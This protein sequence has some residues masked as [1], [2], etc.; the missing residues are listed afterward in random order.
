MTAIFILYIFIYVKMF[1]WY[2]NIIIV[3]IRV[4]LA[5]KGPASSFHIRPPQPPQKIVFI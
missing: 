5:P 4:G 3:I 2:V 1:L